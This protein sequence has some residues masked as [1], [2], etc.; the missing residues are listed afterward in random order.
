MFSLMF[1]RDGDWPNGFL[2]SDLRDDCCSFELYIC[3][4]LS[5]WIDLYLKD[6]ILLSLVLGLLYWLKAVDA[7]RDLLRSAEPL[8]AIFSKAIILALLVYR[9]L[10]LILGKKLP[11]LELLLLLFDLLRLL[12]ILG[13]FSFESL[14]CFS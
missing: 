6:C 10:D 8:F 9:F 11:S 12:S 1:W 3:L 7:T 14:I 4:I 13:E 5:I 2:C